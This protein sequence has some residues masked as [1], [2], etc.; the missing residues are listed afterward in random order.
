MSAVQKACHR[1][2]FG[3]F[4]ILVSKAYYY[5]HVTLCGNGIES[6]NQVDTPKLLGRWGSLT[7]VGS[8]SRG[9]KKPDFKPLPYRHTQSQERL[10]EYTLRRNPELESLRQFIA[11]FTADFLN[12]SILLATPAMVLVP[13]CMGSCLPLDYMSDV[14][15]GGGGGDLLCGQQPVFHITRVQ[16]W[17]LERL[18]KVQI[19]GHLWPTFA[20]HTE[21]KACE[22]EIWR[23]I[24]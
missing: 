24:L 20:T 2:V 17:T 9:R 1:P 19:H 3:H 22:K 14:G 16:A 5:Q 7:L 12:V 10:W 13:H 15:G 21:Q 6:Q 4:F 11:D 23:A 8:S 18:F